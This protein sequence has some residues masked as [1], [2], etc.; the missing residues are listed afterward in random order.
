MKLVND[1]AFFR[2]ADLAVQLHGATGL[3]EDSPEG[4]LFRIARNL[5]V[6][7]GTDEIQKNVIA[8]GLLGRLSK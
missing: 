6:P 2:I 5:R 4:T 1:T 3:L 8:A 7:A